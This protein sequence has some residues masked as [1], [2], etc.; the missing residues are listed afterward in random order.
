MAGVTISDADR[1]SA[2]RFLEEYLTEQLGTDVD[3]SA[4]SALRDL[5]INAL[6]LI[7]AY[8]RGEATLI[9]SRQ[10]L[11]RVSALPEG[12]DRDEAVQDILA[13][14]LISPKTGRQSRGIAVL[15]FS[16]ST[17]VLVPTTAVFNRTAT[18]AYKPDLSE[19]RVYTAVEMR[20]VRDANGVVTTRTLSV[21]VIAMETGEGYDIDPGVFVNFSR[22]NPYLTRIENTRKFTGGKSDETTAELLERAPTALTLRDLVTDRAI[23]TVVEDTFT[24]VDQV[25]VVGF[26]DSEM[27]RDRISTLSNTLNIHVGGHVDVYLKGEIIES[28]LYEAAVGDPFTDPRT[29]V[30]V[31]RDAAVSDFTVIAG[32]VI[33]PVVVGMVIQINNAS[34]GEPTRYVINEVVGDHLR[35]RA[36]NPFPDART[37]VAYT[38]GSNHPDYDNAVIASIT[39]EFSDELERSGSILLPPTP[40]YL[41]RDVSILDSV[42]ILADPDDGRVHLTNRVNT[43]PSITQADRE[44]QIVSINPEATPSGQQVLE[45]RVPSSYDGMSIQVIYD[46]LNEFEEIGSYLVDR[47]NRVAAAN[48]LAKGLHPIY[49]NFYLL[50][51]LR[52]T[53][54]TDV[55]TT[56]VQAALATYINSFP[57]ED[58]LNVSDIITFVQ[59]QFPD[60]GR[61]IPY[62]I[63]STPQVWRTVSAYNE[64]DVVIPA[65]GRSEFF[66]VTVG[67]TTAVGEPDW[68]ATLTGTVVDGTVTYTKIPPYSVSYELYAP[69]GRVIPYTTSDAIR[70]DS[71]RL[72]DPADLNNA[73]DITGAPTSIGMGISSR[74]IRYLTTE[75]LIQLRQ[76]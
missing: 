57:S 26:G 5:T 28:Q 75:E 53:A 20:A 32:N 19:D 37:A 34:E 8:F 13:N 67:G 36:E 64:G 11:R 16:R 7:T 3:L 44:Y 58:V 55:D 4:G 59:T 65:D 17:D 54:A 10:S 24:S 45:L 29:A 1:T 12:A 30:T 18:L 2:E 38:I 76:I 39:G 61:V 40:V 49:I 48:I 23:Q 50:Y 66:L 72:A 74:T 69:D 43:T 62:D 22:I 52:T 47:E 25:V 33:L 73:L 60:V 41:I 56:V 15:H 14:L 35:V 71:A 68:P 51:E 9:R 70:I 63:P 21:P 27:Q 6:S 31:F 42:N 46:T